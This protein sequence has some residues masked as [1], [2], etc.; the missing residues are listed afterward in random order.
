MRISRRCRATPSE[1]DVEEMLSAK[2]RKTPYQR[3][4]A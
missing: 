4:D 1:P 2:G 3:K